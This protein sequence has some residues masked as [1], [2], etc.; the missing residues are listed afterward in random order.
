[1]ADA[2]HPPEPRPCDKC[3]R[4]DAVEFGDRW[5]CPDCIAT[6]GSCCQECEMTDDAAGDEIP[7]DQSRTGNVASAACRITGSS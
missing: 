2:H 3:G 5:L 6:S 1:M 7:A 4:F